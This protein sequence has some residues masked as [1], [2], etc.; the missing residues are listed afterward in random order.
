[1][2]LS[3]APAAG[4]KVCSGIRCESRDYRRKADEYKQQDGG[5]TLQAIIVAHFEQGRW[6]NTS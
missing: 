3:G 1:M 4:G 2:M 6:I 5:E